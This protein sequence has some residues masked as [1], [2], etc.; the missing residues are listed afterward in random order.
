MVRTDFQLLVGLATSTLGNP[1][2]MV[3]SVF[4]QESVVKSWA[5]QIDGFC[6]KKSTASVTY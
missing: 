4:G 2:E 5:A 6:P 1:A 3:L